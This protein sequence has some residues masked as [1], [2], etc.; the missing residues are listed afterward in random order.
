MAPE[1]RQTLSR[2]VRLAGGVLLFIAMLLTI[3]SSSQQG[4]EL[5]RFPTLQQVWSE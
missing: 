4:P 1:T 3:A 5:A 2:I